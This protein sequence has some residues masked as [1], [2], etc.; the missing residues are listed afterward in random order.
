MALVGLNCTKTSC[1][2]KLTSFFCCAVLFCSVEINKSS[3][4][5]FQITSLITS[6]SYCTHNYSGL[7][8]NGAVNTCFFLE[9]IAIHGYIR[10]CRGFLVSRFQA[11][12]L[13]ISQ[14]LGYHTR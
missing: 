9:L 6:K 8:S 10:Q 13:D 3:C 7:P 14:E 2:M 1:G 11:E 12:A 4:Y 5:L